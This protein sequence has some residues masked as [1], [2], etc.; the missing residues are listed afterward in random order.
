MNEAA[1]AADACACRELTFVAIPVVWFAEEELSVNHLRQLML[2]E[3]Q[4]RNF[5]VTAIR[6]YL[7]GVAHFSRFFRRPPDQLGP[8]DIRKYQAM[9]FITQSHV[10]ICEVVPLETRTRKKTNPAMRQMR[11]AI[12]PAPAKD[13]AMV[14]KILYQLVGCSEWRWARK[15]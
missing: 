13:S 12:I 6:T 15:Q 3:L 1:A 2:E 4:R 9:L 11:G 14:S 10:P 5:A 8:E 7:H